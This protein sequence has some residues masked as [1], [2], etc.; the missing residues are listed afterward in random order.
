MA[1]I[2][3]VL[4][5]DIV[6]EATRRKPKPMTFVKSMFMLLSIVVAFIRIVSSF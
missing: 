4:K 2:K 6:L 5:I 3:L 1:Q